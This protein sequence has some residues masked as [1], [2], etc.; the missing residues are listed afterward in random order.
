MEGVKKKKKGSKHLNLATLM[1]QEGVQ[2]TI[3]D[4]IQKGFLYLFEI[5]SNCQ[6]CRKKKQNIAESERGW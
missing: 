6:I 3:E 5:V 2:G 1:E 4:E